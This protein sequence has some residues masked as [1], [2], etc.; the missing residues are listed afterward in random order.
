M[1]LKPA[2]DISP[3][4]TAG[5]LAALAKDTRSIEADIGGATKLL[6]AQAIQGTD[7]MLVVALD[8][9]EAT[10]GLAGMLRVSALAIVLLAIAAAS[11]AGALTA[12]SFRRLSAIRDAMAR[13]GAGG[14]DLTHRL[15]DD[16]VDE[17]A[18]ISRSFNAFV[19]QISS[20]LREIRTGAESMRTATVEIQVGNRDLSHRTEASAANLQQ[21]SAS[22]STLTTSIKQS[23]SSLATA[24]SAANSSRDAAAL[25]VQVVSSAIGTM[26]DV[27]RSS[28]RITEIIG[29]IDGIAF[30]TNILA[31]NAAVEAAR[32][33]ENGRGFAV[34]AGEVRTL[35]QR[36]AVAAREIKDLIQA[37]EAS[38]KAGAASVQAAGANMSE[39]MGRIEQ[40]SCIIGEIND[41]LTVQSAGIVEIDRSVSELDDAT[42]QN[43]ALV[44]QTTTASACLADQALGLSNSVGAFKLGDE[45]CRQRP[46]DRRRARSDA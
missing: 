26:E 27:S 21:T 1:A 11:I 10:A 12:R 9:S 37:S 38:V 15:P 22:L 34:V 17:V 5:V 29:V 40:V 35:A 19:E 18:Q 44:E 36:S 13:I 46:A 20:V 6:R 45:R 32:A 7:W 3:A 2:S 42:Q 28:A 14:G 8:K 31:L 39:I 25:G 16:G 30:Q 41:S 4:L 43:S 23:V 24:T 33:G